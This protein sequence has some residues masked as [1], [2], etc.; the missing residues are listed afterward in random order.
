MYGVSFP[1]SYSHTFHIFTLLCVE[2]SVLPWDT[3]CENSEQTQEW[4]TALRDDFGGDGGVL[5]HA[6]L[7]ACR[8]P[9]DDQ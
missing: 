3:R 8:G 4:T 7:W 9:E 1:N 6:I 2:S 5:A